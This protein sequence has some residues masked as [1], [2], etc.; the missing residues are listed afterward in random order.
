MDTQPPEP[1][2]LSL[3]RSLTIFRNRAVLA[4]GG[5]ALLVVLFAVPLIQLIRLAASSHL[6]S[7]LPAIPAI[8][9]YLMI[10]E[11]HRVQKPFESAPRLAS[12]CAAAS[13]VCL[14]AHVVT[15]ASG[16]D[17]SLNDSLFFPILSLVLMLWMNVALCLG[18]AAFRTYSFPLLFL[19]F[20]VPMPTSWVDQLTFFF[21]HGTADALHLTFSLMPVPVTREGLLFSFPEIAFLVAPQCSGLRSTLVLFVTSVLMARLFLAPGWKRVVLVALVLPIGLLRNAVRIAVIAL[22]SVYV[23]PDI[24]HGSLHTR[25]GQ[26]FFVL[27]LLVLMGALLVLRRIGNKE[28]PTLLESTA[29]PAT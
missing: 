21:Q 22:L 20:M 7:H 3:S 4:F 13:L 2:R 14:L 27:S 18:D 1:E 29:G 15:S 12:A 11:R 19:L 24:A 26:P 17:P 5:A 16:S 8:S 10:R 25:G 9:A 6:F 28:K 23:N